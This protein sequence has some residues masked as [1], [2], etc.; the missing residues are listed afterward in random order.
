[1]AEQEPL[2]RVF[3]EAEAFV[4]RGPAPFLFAQIPDAHSAELRFAASLASY[5]W[6]VVPVTAEIGDLVFKTSLFPRSGSYLLP[7]KVAVQRALTINPGDRISAI[8][9]VYPHQ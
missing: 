8:L 4:W 3:F 2:C 5:G 7:L 1:M 9:A 6:G